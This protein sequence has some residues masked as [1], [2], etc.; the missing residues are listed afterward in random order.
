MRAD[1]GGEDD[2]SAALYRHGPVGLFGHA[3]GFNDHF[4]ITDLAC[5][6]LKVHALSFFRSEN[7][8]GITSLD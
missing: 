5:Y 7:R 1:H 3:A 4:A 6:F 8:E 2:G